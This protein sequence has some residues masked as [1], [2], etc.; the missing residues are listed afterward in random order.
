[1]YHFLGLYIIA[2]QL[3]LLL[4]RAVFYNPFEKMLYALRISHLRV[5][6]IFD[7]T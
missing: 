6:E 2:R 4:L 7:S 5:Y 3:A 1:M